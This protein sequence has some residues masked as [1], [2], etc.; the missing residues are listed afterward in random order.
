MIF[1]ELDIPGVWRITPQPH[2]DERGRFTRLYC[3]DE[4]EEAGIRFQ[5]TQINLSTNPL[6]FTL[7]GLHF[8]N[9]PHAEAK[10][11]RVLRGSIHEVVVDWR[12]DSATRGR[13]IALRLDAMRAEALFIPEGCAHGFLTLEPET[14]LLY[15]MGRIY[16]PGHARGL[17]YD[18]PA[19]GIEW[20][21]EPRLISEADRNWPLIGARS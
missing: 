2:Q 16:A 20:P 4:F 3:P 19:L 11:I 12:D 15:Q 8:Q 5:S 14:E 6:P 21:A 1:E 7:R 13:H 10:F 9:P 17:R 18:D